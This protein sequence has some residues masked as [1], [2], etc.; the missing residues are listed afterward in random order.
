MM[1]YSEQAVIHLSDCHREVTS[2]R[3]AL[4]EQ[5]KVGESRKPRNYPA[6]S[7]FAQEMRE[8]RRDRCL[9]SGK[10]RTSK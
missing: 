6:E 3:A 8:T 1:I 7:N 2:E 9:R 4:Q 5:K 10:A